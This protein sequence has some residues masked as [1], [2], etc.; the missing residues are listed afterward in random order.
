MSPYNLVYGKACHLPIE[1]EHKAY[2]AVKHLNFSTNNYGVLR[3]LELNEL[4][5][6]RHDAYDNAKH[7]KERTKVFH[8]K[9]ILRKSF[10]PNQKVLFY[11]S[12]LHVFANKLRSKWSGPYIVQTVFP[13][14]AVEILNPHNG[15][16]FKVNGQRLKH[17]LDHFSPEDTTIH[18]LDPD[19]PTEP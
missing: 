11:N 14:G 4:E 10:L 17:F 13:H 5:E 18:L 12:T 7:Y 6:L 8:D 3:K 1:L 19:P 16:I 9:H 2:W 15:N